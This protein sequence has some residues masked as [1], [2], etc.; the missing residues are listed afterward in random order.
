MR[1]PS[2]VAFFSC[3]GCNGGDDATRIPFR[4]E[5]GRECVRTCTEERC[6]EDCDADPAPSGACEGDPCFAVDD[7][8]PTDGSAPML[9][10][11]DACCSPAGGGIE[12]AWN[13]GDCSPVVCDADGDCPIGD[14]ICSGERC[15]R[16]E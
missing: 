4:D 14:H 12:V 8:D 2:V 15:V 16:E 3:L 5:A 13:W 6:G 10:L 7:T 11:C 9:V 1:F